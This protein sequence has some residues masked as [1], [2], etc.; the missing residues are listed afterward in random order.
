MSNYR[1]ATPQTV[2][3]VAKLVSKSSSLL[4][5]MVSEGIL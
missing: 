1:Q 4:D 3:E 5:T 2:R